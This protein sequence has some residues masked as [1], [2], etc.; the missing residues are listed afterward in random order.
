MHMDWGDAQQAAFDRIVVC[1][2]RIERAMP[3]AARSFPFR[4]LLW[5]MRLRRR[6]GM[7]LV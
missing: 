2:G 3:R 7:R 1:W 6:L 5:D 4:L